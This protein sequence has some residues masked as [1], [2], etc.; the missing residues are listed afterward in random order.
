MT[1]I[2]DAEITRDGW[3]RVTPRNGGAVLV[4]RHEPSRIT[5]HLEW[6]MDHPGAGW[7]VALA[8]RD[9][10]GDVLKSRESVTDGSYLAA[11]EAARALREAVLWTAE[12]LK[13]AR[14]S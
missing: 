10:D 14:A 8:S 7:F 3:E 4:W 9:D 1:R 2:D 5:V 11:C 13:P 12:G 6:R